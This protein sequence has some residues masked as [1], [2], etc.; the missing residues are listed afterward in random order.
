ML[1][2]QNRLTTNFEF[3]ITRKYGK[4]IDTAYAKIIYLKPTN[5]TGPTRIGI[6]T[7]AHFDKKAVVRNHVKRLFREA[8]RLGLEDLPQ[9]L[10]ISVYP[11][12][13]AKEQSYENIN[14]EIIRFIQK[15]AIS[16]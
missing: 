11:K 5:Y 15:V 4:P 9:N 8:F 14:T 7:S 3:N 6:V 2:S 10:W 13:S 1:K 12:Q 16:R